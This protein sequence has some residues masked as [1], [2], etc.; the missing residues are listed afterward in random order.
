[1][2]LL[3]GYELPSKHL[4]MLKQK[5][6]TH[7]VLM[8]DSLL[9]SKQKSACSHPWVSLTCGSILSHKAQEC[10]HSQASILQLLD[11]QLFQVTLAPA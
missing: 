10:N 4:G 6:A 11:L 8:H 9:P 7:Y 5:E 3:R 2:C 1:M